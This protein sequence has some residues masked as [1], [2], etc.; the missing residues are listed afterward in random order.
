MVKKYWVDKLQLT[1]NAI[2]K[3]GFEYQFTQVIKLSELKK[4]LDDRIKEL[5]KEMKPINK[6][7]QYY[8]HLSDR[9]RE[10]SRIKKELGV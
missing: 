5:E 10:I 8:S 7:S 3:K 4:I 6:L 2:P 9:K 1:A